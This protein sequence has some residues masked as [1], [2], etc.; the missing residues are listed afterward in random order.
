MKQNKNM[1]EKDIKDIIERC[2]A[3]G[4]EKLLMYCKCMSQMY[5]IYNKINEFGMLSYEKE[6]MSLAY[7]EAINHFIEQIKV[8]LELGFTK[9]TKIVEDI[10]RSVGILDHVF[11]TVIHSTNKADGILFQTA[12]LSAGVGHYQDAKLCAYYASF[13]NG[14]SE[15]YDN[16]SN[17]KYT[18]CVYPSL[19]SIPETSILFS[20]RKERGRVSVVKMPEYGTEDVTKIRCR[21]AHELYHV[22]PDELRDRENRARAFVQ[23]MLYAIKSKLMEKYFLESKGEKLDKKVL[24]IIEKHIFGKCMDEIRIKVR[25]NNSYYAHDIKAIV[26][27]NFNNML[28]NFDELK[29]KSEIMEE[30]VD[31]ELV[32]NYA[33]YKENENEI[34]RLLKYCSAESKNMLCRG[35]VIKMSKFYMNLF[36]EVFSDIMTVLT[37]GITE[38]QYDRTFIKV[39]NENENDMRANRPLLYYRKQ[40]TAN[41]LSKCYDKSIV[42]NWTGHETQYNIASGNE[43]GGQDNEEGT[44]L[45]IEMFDKIIEIYNNFFGVLC[46]NFSTNIYNIENHTINKLSEFRKKFGINFNNDLVENGN[47]ENLDFISEKEWLN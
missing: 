18:F 41:A 21:L 2:K 17:E 27:E 46:S 15:V 40:F 43:S 22:L 12:V 14:L 45:I 6:M 35:A 34:L 13:L 5:S 36:S 28:I 9:N 16:S 44:E 7:G 23:I 26:E 42:E 38:K 25:E 31:I 30:L 4:E 32:Q 47:L 33:K 11:Q 8:A 10:E 29:L 37:L 19:C 1:I 3:A 39:A 20:E 24:D